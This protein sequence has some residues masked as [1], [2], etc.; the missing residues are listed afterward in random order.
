MRGGKRKFLIV[1]RRKFGKKIQVS[2]IMPNGFRGNGLGFIVTK[3]EIKLP[4]VFHLLD[5]HHFAH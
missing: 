2:F 4:F 1:K 3:K 5:V